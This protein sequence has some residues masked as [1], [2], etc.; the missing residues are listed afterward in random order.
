M[1][2][3]VHAR[4]HL[5]RARDR[6]ARRHAREHAAVVEQSSQPL[7]RLA[8]PHDE[9]PVEDGGV[10][11][12]RHEAVVERAQSLHQL[13]RRRLDRD[14]LHLGLLLL[15][16][17]TDAHQRAAGAEAGDEDVDLGAV[18]PDLGARCARSA[19]AGWRGCRTGRAA[20]ATGRRRRA[21]PRG[22]WR[23]CCPPRP[24][25]ARSRRRRSRAADAVRP[26]RSRASPRAAGTRAG[27]RPWP[28]RCRCCP[29]TARGWCRRDA[30]PR[31]P[32]P[33]RS[34]SS[35]MRSF[36]EP[37]GFCPSSL[38]KIRTSGFGESACTPTRGVSPMT[39]R[40]FSWRTTSP[41][42]SVPIGRAER[43]APA[44]PPA[45]AGRIE[46]TSPSVTFV[47]SWSRYRMSSSLQ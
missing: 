31:P 21:S 12:R 8:R 27:A 13:A 32:R 46:M 44:Q 34:S 6:R 20:R 23:R 2:P 1:V 33:A 30:A 29:T 41:C 37:P 11:D 17:A 15:E 40:M 9:L 22:G 25:T 18:A 7:D 24:V 42:E 5:R 16:V 43:A 45:T 38:A 47:S 4:R 26:T 36:D 19:R 3:D 35:A 39:P 10:E 28:A 14:D